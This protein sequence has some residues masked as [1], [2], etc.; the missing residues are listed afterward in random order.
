[1]ETKHTP[2]DRPEG[3]GKQKTY[4]LK[5]KAAKAKSINR[6]DRSITNFNIPRKIDENETEIGKQKK[7]KEKKKKGPE[8]TQLPPH[9][10]SPLLQK[11]HEYKKY[12]KK[13]V[14]K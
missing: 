11:Q 3:K 5:L 9:I 14:K 2:K 1:M 4:S 13:K 8:S 6:S 12:K 7:K 10:H